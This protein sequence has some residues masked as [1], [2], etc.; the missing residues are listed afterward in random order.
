MAV[1]QQ[2]HNMSCHRNHQQ[3]HIA[4]RLWHQKIHV[5]LDLFLKIDKDSIK[6]IRC[7]HLEQNHDST[8][9]KM[10]AQTCQYY[11]QKGS[12]TSPTFCVVL[13]ILNVLHCI[14][15]NIS[16]EHDKRNYDTDNHI[17]AWNQWPETGARLWISLSS[18]NVTSHNAITYLRPTTRFLAMK[19]ICN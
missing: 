6:N 4:C 19:N 15:I 2:W 17:A 14:Q 1:M 11:T 9:L 3:C 18:T 13:F 12:C 10:T 8:T 7:C 16:L 5:R